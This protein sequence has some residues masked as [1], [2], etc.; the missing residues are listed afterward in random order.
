[1]VVDDLAQAFASVN[2]EMQEESQ[3]PEADPFQQQFSTSQEA[4]TFPPDTVYPPE[5]SPAIYP[6]GNVPMHS[7]AMVGHGRDFNPTGVS[8]QLEDP[9]KAYH[10]DHGTWQSGLGSDS[11]YSAV[12]MP[13]PPSLVVPP[14]DMRPEFHPNLESGVPRDPQEGN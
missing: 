8:F 13:G 14:V 7:S 11:G 12:G 9:S 2:E 5:S 1:M 3:P 4:E 6:Q 10:Q